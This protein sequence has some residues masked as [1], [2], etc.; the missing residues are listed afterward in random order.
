MLRFPFIA[1]L[2]LVVLLIQVADVRSMWILPEQNDTAP[3]HLKAPRIRYLDPPAP[4]GYWDSA[5]IEGEWKFISDKHTSENLTGC[6]I[7]YN[8]LNGETQEDATY[9]FKDRGIVALFTLFRTISD[10]PGAG[11]WVRSGR[12]TEQSFPIFEI[13]MKQNQSMDGWYKNQT[14]VM[15]RITFDSNPWDRTFA[16]ALPIVGIGILIF[17]GVTCIMAV[18]K[19]TLLILRNGFQ[20][21]MAQVTLWMNVIGCLIRMLFGVVDPFGASGTTNFVFSQ[22]FLTLS[23]PAAISGALLIS[24][25]W[26]EMIKRTGNKINMFLDRM[27]WVFMLITVLMHAFEL[28]T[29]LLRA[30]HYSFNL[31][32]FLDGAMYIVFSLAVF[33]FFVV[34]KIRLQRIFDKINSGLKSRKEQR[35]SLAT[36]QLQAMVVMMVVFLIFLILIGTTSIV[37]TPLSF[38][39]MWSFLF[40]SVQ[41]IGFFQ[42]LLITAPRVP[43]KVIFVGLWRP[44][45]LREHLYN[46]TYSPSG[47]SRTSYRSQTGEPGSSSIGSASHEMHSSRQ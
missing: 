42:V 1:F 32:I 14:R 5:V 23:Y 38:P 29:A 28:A 22:V 4:P 27:R 39:I 36:F 30:Y 8:L 9:W 12:K 44:E 26:H 17:S 7:C 35:L 13:T 19:L 37:W 25:Y 47:T 10:Y 33:I 31:V 3:V 18:W 15:V 20:L 40:I 34:T 2:V 16:I 21:S 41:L 45:T 6:I 24:L 46:D 11:N 43:V